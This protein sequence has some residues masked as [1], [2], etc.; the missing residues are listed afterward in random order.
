MYLIRTANVLLNQYT[1][2]FSLY[3]QN[4]FCAKPDII[5]GRSKESQVEELLNFGTLHH[6]SF[7]ARQV[8]T[9]KYKNI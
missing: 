2:D 7:V 5:L 9:Q 3:L 4:V 8:L 1:Y 6:T